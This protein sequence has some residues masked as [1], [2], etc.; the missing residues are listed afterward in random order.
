MNTTKLL[1]FSVYKRL[2]MSN[3][4]TEN[5]CNLSQRKYRTQLSSQIMTKAMK[6]KN[7]RAFP[8]KWMT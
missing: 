8:E 3:G 5:Y 4:E 7:M 6:I 2:A 1:N